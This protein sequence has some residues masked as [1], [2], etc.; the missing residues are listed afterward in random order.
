MNNGAAVV[1]LVVDAK[2]TLVGQPQ[3]A[4]LG[5]VEEG[6]DEET[7]ADTI[8]RIRDAVGALKPAEKRNDEAVKEAALAVDGRPIHI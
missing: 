3:L 1:T 2:G 6:G 4:L 7:V 5:L 8:D